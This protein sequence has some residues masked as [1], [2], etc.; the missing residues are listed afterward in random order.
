MDEGQSSLFTDGPADGLGGKPRVLIVDDEQ[1][2]LRAYARVL[3]GHGY[4]V[5]TAASGECGLELLQQN[6][7]DVVISDLTMPGMTGIEFLREVRQK[8]PDLPVILMTA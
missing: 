1:A 8:D 5:S 3:S 6:A 7:I 4:V 2:I